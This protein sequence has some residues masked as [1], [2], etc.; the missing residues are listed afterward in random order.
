MIVW[1]LHSI[2]LEWAASQNAEFNE[3][4]AQMTCSAS[5]SKLGGDGFAD[6]FHLGRRYQ[7]AELIKRF[8]LTVVRGSIPFITA[9]A[10]FRVAQPS[11]FAGVP[12]GRPLRP[13]KTR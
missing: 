5:K 11:P 2:P 9:P 1:F 6:T 10:T 8:L 7:P 4:S 12:S 13:R 3:S